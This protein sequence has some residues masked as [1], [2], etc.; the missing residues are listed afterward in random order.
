VRARGF[1]RGCFHSFRPVIGNRDHASGRFS[2]GF[3]KV[4]AAKA[5]RD[6]FRTLPGALL[7]MRAVPPAA[8]VES[9]R[10]SYGRSGREH[11]HTAIDTIIKWY[12]GAGLSPA[13]TRPRVIEVRRAQNDVTGG[14]RSSAS[15]RSLRRHVTS[16]IVCIIASFAWLLSGL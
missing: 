8:H 9:S 16:P 2:P 7:T 10:A 1:A 14:R 4:R 3:R 5:R 15:A 12:L 13:C 11:H 6:R